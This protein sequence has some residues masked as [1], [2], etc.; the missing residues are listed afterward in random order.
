M[1]VHIKFKKAPTSKII[2]FVVLLLVAAFVI[3]CCYEMHR[4]DNLDALAYIAPAV[5]GLGATAVGFYNWRAKQADKAQI[6]LKRLDIMAELKKKHG[7]NFPTEAISDMD[8][9]DEQVL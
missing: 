2:I 1:D 6:E 7:E 3:W 5:L 4:L 8:V 9:S